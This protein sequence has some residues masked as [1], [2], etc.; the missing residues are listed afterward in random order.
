MVHKILL[1]AI[2]MT[3]LF[4]FITLNASATP[5]AGL[6]ASPA[7]GMV[8]VEYR[9]NQRHWHHRRWHRVRRHY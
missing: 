9:P 7:H 3:G 2:A 5:S 6:H 8:A 4:T 1:A